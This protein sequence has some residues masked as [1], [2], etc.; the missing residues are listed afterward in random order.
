MKKI[1]VISLII[2]LLSVMTCFSIGF[3]DWIISFT[4]I[5]VDSSFIVDDHE[6]SEVHTSEYITVNSVT[7]IGY[8]VGS[9]FH[10]MTTTEYA[11]NINITINTS[12]NRK[13]AA[14]VGAIRS[15]VTSNSMSL[16][17]GVKILNTPSLISNFTMSSVPTSD[18]FSNTS[19]VKETTKTSTNIYQI[20]N[21]GNVTEI[22][23]ISFSL[24]V[25][26]KYTGS[27]DSFPDLISNK[28]SISMLLGEYDNA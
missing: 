26:I 19:V 15:L 10:D 18:D 9:G 1:S 25:N 21:I 27:L 7:P 12:F 17:V 11:D 28:I 2:G 16:N 8:K 5:D 13:D 24:K 3:S 22:D 6:P 23:V 14:D 4:M 20:W